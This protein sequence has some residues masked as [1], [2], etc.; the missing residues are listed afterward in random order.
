[1]AKSFVRPLIQVATIFLACGLIIK[2][3]DALERRPIVIVD[4]SV[5][6]GVVQRFEKHLADPGIPIVSLCVVKLGNER[7]LCAL[8]GDEFICEGDRVA[9]YTIGYKHPGQLSSGSAKAV[10]VACLPPD[11]KPF[12]RQTVSGY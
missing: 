3:F 4:M 7:L 6:Y 12:L 9:V 1:M 11:R 5:Q 2:A 10:V 8:K